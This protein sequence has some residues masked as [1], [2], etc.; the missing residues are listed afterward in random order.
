MS[1]TSVSGIS[2]DNAFENTHMK[3]MKASV[4]TA[5]PANDHKLE[6]FRHLRS[7]PPGVGPSQTADHHP[8]PGT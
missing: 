3:F 1:K 2:D 7:V 4:G 6:K 8:A 5:P